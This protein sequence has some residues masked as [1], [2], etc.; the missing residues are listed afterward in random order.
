VASSLGDDEDVKTSAAWLW[1]R[2]IVIL[3]VAFVW[4]RFG[5]ERGAQA[6][7]V[8][9]LLQAAIYL[10]NGRV[11]YGW[12]GAPPSGYIEGAPAVV[13]SLLLGALALWM[14]LRPR[15]PGAILDFLTAR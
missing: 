5:G 1:F 13:L 9:L 11:P 7:G 14:I 6:G 12:R 2:A 4:Y 3:A 10:R 8:A 15:V